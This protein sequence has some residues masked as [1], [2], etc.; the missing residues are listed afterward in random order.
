MSLPSKLN[1]LRDALSPDSEILTDA[2]ADGFRGCLKRWTDIDLKTPAAIV[3]P[4]SEEDI[5]KT[6]R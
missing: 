6:V 2:T 4:T 5:Q 1:A 3:L